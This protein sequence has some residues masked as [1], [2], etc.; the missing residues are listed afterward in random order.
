MDD[1]RTCPIFL[2]VKST[3]SFLLKIH[4]FVSLIVCLR[5]AYFIEIEIF[6]LKVLY[7]KIN[8]SWNSTVG[9]MNSS[10]NKLNSKINWQK[11]S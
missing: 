2:V 3:T 11:I 10:K 7:I 1:S 6:L 9:F 5:S 8:V 4:I